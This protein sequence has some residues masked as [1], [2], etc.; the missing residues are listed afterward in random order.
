MAIDTAKKRLSA[1]NFGRGIL[2]PFPDGTIDSGDKAT[3]LNLY[4]GFT[5]DPPV[6]DGGGGL[7]PIE[8]LSPAGGLSPITGL[9]GGGLTKLSRIAH[10][11]LEWLISTGKKGVQHASKTTIWQNR[12]AYYAVG[13]QD[14]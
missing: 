3:L 9:G 7:S 10:T 5:L 12:S 8:G 4:N 14:Q 2:L 13:A 6:V 1:L 11:A